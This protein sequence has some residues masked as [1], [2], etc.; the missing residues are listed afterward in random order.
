MYKTGLRKRLMTIALA[1]LMITTAVPV[2]ADEPKPDEMPHNPVYSDGGAT[3]TD[4]RFD[5]ENKNR[6]KT[7]WSYIYFGSYPQSEVQDPALQEK[8]SAELAKEK[9][10]T[11]DVEIEGIKYRRIGADDVNYLEKYYW[12]KEGGEIVPY[13][14]FKWEP[15]RWKVLQ[16]DEDQDKL[17]VL[18]DQALDCQEY[19]EEKER[20]TWE[21]CTLRKWLN[22][23]DFTERLE[24]RSELTHKSFIDT[25]FSEDQKK[26][27]ALTEIENKKSP[28]YHY[29][30]GNDTRDQIFLLSFEEVTNVA[31]GFSGTYNQE[32]IPRTVIPT[33]YAYVMGVSKETIYT[34]YEGNCIWWLRSAGDHSGRDT[35]YA[36]YS[37]GKV[38]SGQYI[39]ANNRGVVPAMNLELSSKLWSVNEDGS[40]HYGITF[41]GNGVSLTDNIK[42]TDQEGKV[43]F[44]TVSR[45]GYIFKGWFTEKEGGEQVTEST[46]FTGSATVYARW[47]KNDIS[48]GESITGPETDPKTD[49]KTD[50]ETDPTA[51]REVVTPHKVKLKSAKNNKK[52]TVTIKI[53]V[54]KTDPK[55]E[56]YELASSTSRKKLTRVK[57]VKRFKK[58]SFKLRKLKKGKT[59]YIRV[60]AFNKDAEGNRI[61]GKWS[62]SK[63]VKIRK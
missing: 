58:T 43:I 53:K 44:P 39:I 63:A 35:V 45:E 20:I 38:D 32:C 27:I 17:F 12:P 16:V 61:Y 46:V 9:K 48:E 37:G 34:R 47:S 49:P 10:S 13:R 3:W 30:G 60:R 29:D 56:G 26:I 51:Q 4:G 42:G 54:R 59:Y 1:G 36:G 18:A 50:P 22:G 11:G 5:E 8:I 2:V 25:A 33:D 62:K 31:Y 21:N 40:H 55:P 41:D 24:K 23:V 28:L 7:D 6:D 57:K 52:G 19:H 14:Y 15:I